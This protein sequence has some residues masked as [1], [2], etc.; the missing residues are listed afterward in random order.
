MSN[1]ARS[2]PASKFAGWAV[3]LALFAGLSLG[4]FDWNPAL[5]SYAI[6]GY[7]PYLFFAVLFF[8]ALYYVLADFGVAPAWRRFWCILLGVVYSCPH[9]WLGTDRFYRFRRGPLYWDCYQAGMP[10]PQPDWFWAA[11][12]RLPAI[13][14]E[15]VFFFLLLSTGFFVLIAW[16]KTHPAPSEARGRP[17]LP[18]AVFSLIL[19]QTWLHL[20][21]RSPYTYVPHYDQPAQV[22]Y[23]HH[24]YLF[25]GA[26][27]AVNGDYHIFCSAELMFLGAA[28]PLVVWP[29][30]LFPMFISSP[31]SA[32][33]NPYY[34]WIAINVLAWNLACIAIYY[35]ALNEFGRHGAAFSALLMASAQGMIAYVAQPKIYVLAIAGVAI[36][37][38]LQQRLF[39]AKR[40][41][42][43]GALLF[44]AVCALFLLTYENQ[45]WLI[46]L[47]LIA[48]LRGFNMRWT[49]LSLALAFILDESFSILFQHLPRIWPIAGMWGPNPLDSITLLLVDLRA[50]E[51]MRRAMLS[52]TGFCSVMMHAFNFCLIPALG[53]FFLA[54]AA[55][56]RCLAILAVGLPAFLTYTL[57]QMANSIYYTRYPRLVYQAYPLVY[58]LGGLCLARLFERPFFIGRLRP[59]AWAAI[60]VVIFHFVWVNADVF[61][62]P[63][64]YYHWFYRTQ[65]FG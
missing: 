58:L 5:R 42:P 29:G 21:M 25:E 18:F 53:S 64:I 36:L 55:T 23:W 37:L 39:E 44:G 12:H 28:R 61:G 45:P 34:V 13:P 26:K 40:P 33:I 50:F 7:V 24:K 27:G 48:H 49:S 65:Q 63:G 9:H 57:F 17:V 2:H 20:S 11:A 14:H 56:K 22:N 41:Q 51:F 59:W 19:F 35:L 60:L 38:A 47:V 15:A 62:Y 52:V 30:R 4:R 8:P 46:G 32:Y 16:R 54:R 3:C 6:R 43:A 31:W 1:L 10:P